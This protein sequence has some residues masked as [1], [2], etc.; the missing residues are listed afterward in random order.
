MKT[1][2]IALS[3]LASSVASA[4]ILIDMPQINFGGINVPVSEVCMKNGEIFTKDQITFCAHSSREW[5]ATGRKRSEGYF[6]TV[7]HAEASEVL[8]RPVT[9]SVKQCVRWE[10]RR[11]ENNCARYEE[12]TKTIPM[13]Y[14]FGVY[15]TWYKR[16]ELMKDL[17]ETRSITIPVCV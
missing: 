1:T 9:Y 6:R 10:G 3:L 16:G 12:V 14:K 2:M 13:T 4:N 5:V 8:S 11:Y 15:K 7:C 17:I